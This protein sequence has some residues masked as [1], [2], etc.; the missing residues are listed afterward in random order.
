MEVCLRRP[1]GWTVWAAR[2]GRFT[3][4]GDVNR[5]QRHA[6]ERAKARREGKRYAAFYQG[7]KAFYS[8]E[9]I[10]TCPYADGEQAGAWRNGWKYA[11]SEQ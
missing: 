3:T 1:A 10:D 7:H 9:G 11:E 5:R 2:S 6:I 4:E 8:G